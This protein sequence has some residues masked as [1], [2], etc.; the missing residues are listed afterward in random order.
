MKRIIS[1]SFGSKLGN[2]QVRTKFLGQD[3]Y[4][5]R[6]G[7]D[8]DVNFAKRLM[9]FLDIPGENKKVP[10]EFAALCDLQGEPFELGAKA[11]AIGL[12]GSTVYLW[13]GK[14]FKEGLRLKKALKN[15]PLL[16][17][18]GLKMTLEKLVV[19]TLGGQGYFRNKKVLVTSAVDREGMA[20]AFRKIYKAKD[21]EDLMEVVFGDLIYFFGI[22]KPI[23]SLRT[24]N[25]I[26]DISAPVMVNLPVSFFFPSGEK[27]KMREPKYEEIQM[28]ADVIAGDSHQILK[29]LPPCGLEGKTIITNT[30]TEHDVGEL[31]WKGVLTLITTTPR[32]EGRSFGTNV[33]EALLVA[34]GAKV[35]DPEGYNE[36]IKKAGWGPNILKL[37]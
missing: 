11:D 32:F 27:Q 15:T 6:I 17:G 34:C 28:W 13:N 14:I 25:I 26:A 35:M 33:M 22:Q 37:N 4:I 5:A 18:Y 29:H 20:R 36:L 10:S 30:T 1:V 12:G 8:G 7:T 31:R 24:I 23:R 21:K 2:H 3:V 19:E 9:V 16:D